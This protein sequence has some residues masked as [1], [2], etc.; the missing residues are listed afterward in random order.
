MNTLP[1]TPISTVRDLLRYAVSRFTR[2]KLFFGHGSENA[3]DEA[4]YLIL[5]TL[6]LPL[7]RVP[8]PFLSTR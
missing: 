5:H 3:F 2:E 7:D 6:S 8:P 1:D 4:A